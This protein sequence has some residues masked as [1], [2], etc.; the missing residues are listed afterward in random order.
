VDVHGAGLKHRGACPAREA[1][2]AARKV[3]KVPP[4][5]ARVRPRARDQ[6]KTRGRKGRTRAVTPPLDQSFSYI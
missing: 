3:T 6:R 2:A 1:E 5:H 4:L